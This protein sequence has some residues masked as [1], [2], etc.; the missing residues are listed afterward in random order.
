MRT[1]IIRSVVMAGAI[2]SSASCGSESGPATSPSGTNAV[3]TATANLALVSVEPPSNSQ[4]SEDSAVVAVLTYSV[5][6]FT[7]DQF[8]VMAQ[9]ETTDPNRTTDGS[10]PSTGYPVLQTSTGTLTFTFPIRHVWREPTVNRPFRIW[11]YVNYRTGPDTSRVI[12]RAGPVE[13][14]AR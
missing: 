9:V 13:Y 12:G 11:F 7:R 5:T 14:A 2:I 10:F 3:V 4:V 6:E 1:Q 8:F